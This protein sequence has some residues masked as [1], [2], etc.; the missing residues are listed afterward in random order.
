MVAFSWVNPREVPR[1][2]IV[3]TS[4]SPLFGCG[5]VCRKRLPPV[6]VDRV[7]SI[8]Q[9]QMR[10]KWS[11]LLRLLIRS[12]GTVPEDRTSH[13]SFFVQLEL[14]HGV[15]FLLGMVQNDVTHVNSQAARAEEP[16]AASQ[17]VSEATD[18]VRW[19]GE[20]PECRPRGAIR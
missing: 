2:S 13:E 3:I 7:S 15:F 12:F 1:T 9:K 6:I 18:P 14:A 11:R 16:K 20:R 8:K 19:R 4:L 5:P 17:V 10:M